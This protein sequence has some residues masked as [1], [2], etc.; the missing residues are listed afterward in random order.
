MDMRIMN[1][2]IRGLFWHSADALVA[3][4]RRTIM[5]CKVHT[6]LMEGHKLR[7]SSARCGSNVWPRSNV[8]A[9][10]RGGVR[11]E[12][13]EAEIRVK[14]ESEAES[15]AGQRRGSEV[16][17]SQRRV[18]GGRRSQRR[19]LEAGVRGIGESEAGQR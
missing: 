18:R 13:S 15:E 1:M 2:D 6:D 9:Q 4:L 3:M 12:R 8:Y 16:E 14:G 10:I 5:H 7:N 17:A 19:W 11:G